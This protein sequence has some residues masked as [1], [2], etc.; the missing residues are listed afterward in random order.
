MALSSKKVQSKQM[1]SLDEKHTEM[2]DIFNE[3]ETETIPRL[4][5]EIEELKTQINAYK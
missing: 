4:Q 1:T 5:I 2:L 3:N